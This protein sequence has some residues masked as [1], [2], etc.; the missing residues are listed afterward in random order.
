MKQVNVLMVKAMRRINT[1]LRLAPIFFGVLGISLAPLTSSAEE[2]DAEFYVEQLGAGSF[3]ERQEAYQKLLT[4]GRSARE[5]VKAA[6]DSEDLEVKIQAQKLWRVVYHIMEAYWRVS[7][8][9]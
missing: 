5:A 3:K 6:L 4:M 9:C 2:K 8:H 7:M 1:M